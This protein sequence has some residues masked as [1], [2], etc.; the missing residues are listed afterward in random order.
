VQAGP[1]AKAP[2]RLLVKTSS[3][4]YVVVRVPWD[5]L[6]AEISAREKMKE[7]GAVVR[8]MGG[9][10]IVGTERH[11][12]RRIDLQLRGR[13]G[14]QRVEQTRTP[15][16]ELQSPSRFLSWPLPPWQAVDAAGGETVAGRERQSRSPHS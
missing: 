2:L 15:L 11:E 5:A 8:D 1:A 13:C 7:E 9:L 12:A 10:Q 4:T 3:T 14:R 6:V 16:A